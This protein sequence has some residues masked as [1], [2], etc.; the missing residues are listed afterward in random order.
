MPDRFQATGAEYL[1]FDTEETAD[2]KWTSAKNA[3]APAAKASNK[4][5]G[6]L[7]L[8]AESRPFAR[9][10]VAR[11][12]ME[13]GVVVKEMSEAAVLARLEKGLKELEQ[14]TGRS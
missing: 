11:C 8:L 4:S 1:D 3:G 14:A 7:L 10:R 9:I 6:A 5:D 12:E 2:M 13:E